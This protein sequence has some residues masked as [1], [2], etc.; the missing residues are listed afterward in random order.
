M[1]A[2]YGDFVLYRP[3]FQSSTYLLW[4]G[5]VVLLA[6]V[7]VIVVRRV[8]AS[9]ASAVDD[10]ALARARSLLHEDETRK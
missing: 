7:L 3:R 1:V 8:R 5:P 9:Q 6:I 2:R 10:D 4:L